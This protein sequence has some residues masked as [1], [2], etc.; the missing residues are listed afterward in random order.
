MVTGRFW[1]RFTDAHSRSRRDDPSRR[2]S[3]DR[4]CPTGGADEYVKLRVVT[5]IQVADDTFV[6]A[7]PE[8]A[9]E[10]VGDRGRWRRWWPDLRLEVVE[11]RGTAG[12]RWRVSGPISGSME[13]WCES[14]LDG[15]VLHYFLHA[16]PVG[17]VPDDAR[18]RSDVLAEANRHRRVAGRAMSFEVKS[19]LEDGRAVGDPAVATASATDSRVSR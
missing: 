9:T 2:R 8:L 4:R 5:S 18:S 19:L 16:E 6:A 7:A 17:P 1:L 12:V 15:F 10:V 3:V 11:D 14:V 13:I